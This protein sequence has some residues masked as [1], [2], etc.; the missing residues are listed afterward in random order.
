MS[1]M[2]FDLVVGQ[3]GKVKVKPDPTA[4]KQILKEFDVLPEN[5]Y[6][7]GDGETDVMTS[8]N[9]GSN[10]IAVLWGYRTKEQLKDAGAKVFA[11]SPKELLD[12]ITL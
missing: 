8:I 7:V 1:D 4:A 9:L 6:F 10:G 2:G 11:N 5:C 3:S 12:L